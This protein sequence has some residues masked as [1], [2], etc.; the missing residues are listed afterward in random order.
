LF[1][2]LGCDDWRAIAS[3]RDYESGSLHYALAT[4]FTKEK[5][6][7][8]QHGNYKLKFSRVGENDNIGGDNVFFFLLAS[9]GS[10]GQFVF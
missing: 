6:A 2:R 9:F 10:S 4:S 8:K 3:L 5:R 7:H 1:A